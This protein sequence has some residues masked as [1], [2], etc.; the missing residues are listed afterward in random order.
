MIASMEADGSSKY[1]SLPTEIAL[2]S[3][4][5]IIALYVYAEAL[6]PLL[7]P[8]NNTGSAGNVLS[9]ANLTE[10]LVKATMNSLK[11]KLRE[12]TL[13][14]SI[15][16]YLSAAIPSRRVIL[17]LD[18]LEHLNFADIPGFAL[19]LGELQREKGRALRLHRIVYASRP[20]ALSSLPLLAHMTYIYL[21]QTFMKKRKH[22]DF[23][24]EV[25]NASGAEKAS[26][27]I[28]ESMLG[29]VWLVNALCSAVAPDIPQSAMGYYGLYEM[30]F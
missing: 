1:F 17:L 14:D 10:I 8:T 7:M 21:S 16:E 29:D 3:P 20:A 28:H 5:P 19:R 30:S 27:L 22:K 23:I 15:S 24:R 26:T 6:Y 2:S 18:S 25:A 13:P 9:D 11:R 4:S 12:S